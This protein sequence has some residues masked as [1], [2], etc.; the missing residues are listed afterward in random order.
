MAKKINIL[1]I[2]TKVSQVTQDINTGATLFNE[3]AEKYKGKEITY[4]DVINDILPQIALQL[5][6]WKKYTNENGDKFI[7][8]VIG[9]INAHN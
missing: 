7:D 1:E 8:T 2:L 3:L 4:E 9:I 6:A 5:D